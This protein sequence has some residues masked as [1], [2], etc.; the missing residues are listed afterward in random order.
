METGP[1]T[2]LWVSRKK[3]K[4]NLNRGARRKTQK[5]TVK[6][7]HF[8]RRKMVSHNYYNWEVQKDKDEKY[9]PEVH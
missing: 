3:K 6:E 4:G 5:N 8:S 1:Q 7:D 2:E 9:P